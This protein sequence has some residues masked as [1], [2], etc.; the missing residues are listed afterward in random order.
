MKVIKLA[1]AL[2]LCSGMLCG[3]EQ[4]NE[5]AEINSR[6]LLGFSQLGSESSWRLGNSES[7]QKAA[8]KADVQLMFDNANQSQQEQINEIRSF[9]A[10][11]VD[12]IAFTPIVENGWD[13][14]LSEAK[15]AN[16]PIIL[17]DRFINTADDSLYDAYVGSDFYKEGICAG[18]F[19]LRKA[20]AIK[21]EHLNVVEISG[22]EDSTP[23]RQRYQGF[24]DAIQNDERIS[25]LESVSGDFLISKGKECMEYLLKKYKNKIN[26]LYA[27]NDGMMLGALEAIEEAGYIPGKDIIIISIDAE[28]KAIDMLKAGKVNCV[29]ECTPMLGDAVMDLAKKL[30]DG[31]KVQRVTYSEERMFTEFDNLDN[32]E[33]RGY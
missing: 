28:Q 16:I 27:H 12:V 19:L 2:L 6:L 14:I 26:V 8:K 22:T 23:M 20:D 10:Y 13:N 15:K 1:I 11:R 21:A 4:K 7:I 3:C 9:I 17:V 33:P 30:V 32:L 25:I 31:E 29:V 18:E 24:R 5:T